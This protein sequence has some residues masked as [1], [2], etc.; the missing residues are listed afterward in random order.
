MRKQYIVM[1]SL[2]IG[3]SMVLTACSP[4]AAPTTTPPV[5][6]AVTEVATEAVPEGMLPEVDPAS[7]TGDINI[8]GSSTVYPLSEAVAENFNKDGF[9]GN[10]NIASVGTGGG[11]E[12]F[13]KTGETDI[14][15]ASRAIKDSEMEA[16]AALNPARVPLEFRVGT[17]AIAV[18]VS[19]ENTFAKDITLDELGLLFTSAE[20]W[21]D[22]RADWPAEPIQRFTPGTDSGTFDFFVEVVIQK[23]QKIE[24]L[25]DAKKLALDAT[26]IQTSEDDNVLVQGVEGS[27][28]AIGYFGFAYYKQQESRLIAL[29]VDGI[30]P[31]FETAESGEYVLARP[32]FIYSDANVLKQK[33]QVA[34]FINYFLTYVNE[35]IDDVG[36]FPA[37]EEALKTARQLFLDAVK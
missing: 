34:G 37:S 7:L 9:T 17:D 29:S 12:R 19:K 1:V 27:P 36:Y 30:A 22:V 15:N 10:V 28:Y 5:T 18:V 21:S 26:N 33:P 24:K 6:E 14:A 4:T 8:A 25:D 32:L 31:S 23:P 3:L 20:K 2:V 16:C 11:F 13:C 35:W